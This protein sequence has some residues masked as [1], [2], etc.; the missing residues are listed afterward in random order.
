MTKPAQPLPRPDLPD[1]DAMCTDIA[2][3]HARARRTAKTSANHRRLAV[4]G[5]RWLYHWLDR[6][7]RTGFNP[8]AVVKVPTQDTPLTDYYTP[9]Q[10]DAMLASALSV[11]H[12]ARRDGDHRRWVRARLEHALMATM[13][14]T[15][16]RLEELATLDI[17][18]IDFAQEHLVVRR[19]KGGKSREVP[20]ALP[21]A[22]VLAAYLNDV[23]PHCPA[24]PRL[25]SNPYSQRDG[26]YYGAIDPRAIFDIVRKHGLAAGIPGR[27]TSP[28]YA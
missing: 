11:A 14:Y 10:F 25:W 28:P 19:G 26:S 27:H 17:D 21:A 22:A 16:I 1:F 24:S 8:A 20:L 9:E 4:Y 3:E 7:T 18:D 2:A 13:R 6:D 12:Q 23:R 15:G 5:A